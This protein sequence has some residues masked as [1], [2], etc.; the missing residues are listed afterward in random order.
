MKKI[1]YTHEVIAVIEKSNSHPEKFINEL[2]EELKD[3]T[4]KRLIKAY[5]GSDPLG[6]MES[7]LGKIL[8]ETLQRED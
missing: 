2:L 7:E 3:P 8:M 4:H 1:R 5:Q 6:S